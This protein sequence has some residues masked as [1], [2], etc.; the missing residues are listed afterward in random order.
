[1]SWALSLGTRD[2]MDVMFDVEKD[3]VGDLLKARPYSEERRAQLTRELVQVIDRNE[4]KLNRSELI[5]LATFLQPP[6]VAKP[7]IS[8]KLAPV[9]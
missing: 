2:A 8:Q 6:A 1:M 4:T 3:K 5:L 9:Q 7:E